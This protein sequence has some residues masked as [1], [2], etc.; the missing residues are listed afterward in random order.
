MKRCFWCNLDNPIYVSYHDHEWG[1][2]CLEDDYLF[3][4]LILESYQAGLSWECILNKREAF[5][6]A[7]DDFD[8]LKVAHYD[9]KKQD[10]LAHNP[11]IVRNR[12]KI[13]ASIENAKI[14][15]GIQKEFGSFKNYLESFTKGEILYE[16]GKTTNSLSDTISNDLKRRGMKFVGSVIIYSYL[17]AIGIINSHEKDCFLYDRK[18]KEG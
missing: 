10:E 9:S 15:I 6:E 4:M 1:R 5:R 11:L 16:L 2:L 12:L 17:Q 3:E 14:F 13:K 18:E 7:Y 8:V